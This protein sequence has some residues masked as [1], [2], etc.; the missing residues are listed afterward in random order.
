[1]QAITTVPS[2]ATPAMLELI[3]AMVL[4]TEPETQDVSC[5]ILENIKIQTRPHHALL[6]LLATQ[7][8]VVIVHTIM[9]TLVIAISALWVISQMGILWQTP[10][11][12]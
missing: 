6:A 8:L 5:A 2:I 10:L 12:V 9:M 3:R 7:P 1:M 11:G 4:A